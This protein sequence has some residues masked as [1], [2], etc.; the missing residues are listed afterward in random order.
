MSKG[1]DTAWGPEKACLVL[2]RP[3]P[4]AAVSWGGCAGSLGSV[5]WPQVGGRRANP[6]LSPTAPSN[7]KKGTVLGFG[8][9]KGEWLAHLRGQPRG[10][11]GAGVEG[12]TVGA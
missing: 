10:C 1:Q 7:P 4:G 8:L 5:C 11:E 3:C 12:F 2:G 6:Q 9:W